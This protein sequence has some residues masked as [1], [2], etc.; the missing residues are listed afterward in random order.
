MTGSALAA[1]TA[2][3][4][5]ADD[6]DRY[7]AHATTHQPRSLQRRLGP[8]DLGCP[9]DRRLGYHLA[10]VPPRQQPSKWEAYLGTA[11]HA[12]MA[13]DLATIPWQPRPGV[14]VP[15]FLV[16]QRLYVG[17]LGGQD[18]FGTSDAYD[19]A[20][21][22]VIDW[23]L[24]GKRSLA[25]YRRHGA[26]PGY[27][28]QGQI[29][30]KGWRLKGYP[31]DGITIAFMPRSERYGR[32]HFWHQPFNEQ[33]ADQALA[34]GNAIDAAI[35]VAGPQALPHLRTAD[36]QCLWCPWFDPASRDV[37]QGCPGELDLPRITPL[38]PSSTT[39]GL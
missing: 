37:T 33:I 20:T 26:G 36:A 2:L 4:D 18:I 1:A 39:H 7:I 9:C 34:R 19:Q 6:I 15:R 16:E 38:T 32:R 29:Y 3:E 35:K 17:Q 5:L 11:F 23:K 13:R 31:V 8:S 10:G 28:V 30:G 12:Q 27:S 22:R 21:N 24:V 25:H 14:V